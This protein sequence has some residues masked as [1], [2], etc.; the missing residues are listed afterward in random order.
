MGP[1]TPILIVLAP[2]AGKQKDSTTKDTI[3]MTSDELILFMT[4]LL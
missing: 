4:A 3:K 1:I 2:H